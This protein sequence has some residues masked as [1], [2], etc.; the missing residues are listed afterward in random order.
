MPSG[1]RDGPATV[2]WRATWRGTWVGQLFGEQ[3]HEVEKAESAYIRV[4]ESDETHEGAA[5][6]LQEIYRAGER[7]RELRRLLERRKDLAA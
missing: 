5:R 4:L 6:A 7:F 2:S 3:L 1:R